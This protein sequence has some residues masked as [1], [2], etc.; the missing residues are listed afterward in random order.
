MDLI[1]IFYKHNLKGPLIQ[2]KLHQT[3]VFVSI[4][5]RQKD[6]NWPTKFAPVNCKSAG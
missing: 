1:V 6:T 5:A 2:T 4:N 3:R